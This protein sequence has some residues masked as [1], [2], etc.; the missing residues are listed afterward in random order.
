MLTCQCE[1]SHYQRAGPGLFFLACGPAQPDSNFS[2]HPRGSTWAG[3]LHIDDLNIHIDS[4]NIHI[5]ADNN[6]LVLHTQISTNPN[7]NPNPPDLR[8]LQKLLSQKSKLSF[9]K[10][11]DALSLFHRMVQMQPLPPVIHFNQLLS[12]VLTF[13]TL[14]NAFCK[15][16]MTKEAENVL[17]FM[18]QRGVGP[19]V[20]TYSTLMMVIAC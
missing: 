10:L 15:E 5:K 20:V 19:D 16:G 2:G 8:Q 6:A 4:V 3:P 17:E 12:D 18:V 7:P 11:D 13:N 9:D 14:I 1:Y